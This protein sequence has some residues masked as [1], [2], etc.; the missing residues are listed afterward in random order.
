MSTENN[1]GLPKRPRKLGLITLTSLVIANMIGAGIFTTSGFALAD[2]GSPNVV[3][4]GWLLGGAIALCGAL[5]YGALSDHI[6]ESG[7]EYLF[8]SRLIHP[9][10]GFI[11]GTVSLIAGFTGAIA[12]A[13]LAFESYF[14]PLL[15]WELPARSVAIAT[16]L[17]AALLHGVK[18]SV[19]T[20]VQNIVVGLKLVLIF[21]FIIAAAVFT[22]SHGT[23]PA[24][25]S[26]PA[27]SLIALAGSLVWISLSYSGYNA[28][29]YVAGEAAKEKGL[30]ARSMWLGTVLVWVIYLLLNGTF[31]YLVPF[32]LIAGKQ[33][34]AAIAAQYIGGDALTLLV[35][36]I[37]SVSLAT[38]VFAMIMIGPRVYAQMADDGLFPA[39]LRTKA[40]VPRS[41]IFF[42]AAAAAIFVIFSDI[43]GL[44]SYLGLTLSLCAALTVS[45][46]FVLK[47][48]KDIAFTGIPG[49]PFVSGIFI[50]ATLFLAILASINRPAEFIGTF[51]TFAVGVIAYYALQLYRKRGGAEQE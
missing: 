28:A 19:G 38:S 35:R 24:P 8:L 18:D 16:I 5:S 4:L 26:V 32:D 3:M 50:A 44:L 34:V 20:V 47:R 46:L 48:R 11:A 14:L 36:V 40:D 22:G 31:V 13:A 33:D 9:L 42:Q 27:F 25:A 30:V 23:A 37:I 6:S 17:L 49:Y 10:L 7:G 21:A 39:I 2:L 43:Q 1:V 51:V 15:P 29:V 41:S 12:I 45:C